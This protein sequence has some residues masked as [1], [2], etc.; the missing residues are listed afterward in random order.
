MKLT[1]FLP[2][3][4]DPLYYDT[5]K[6]L[7]DNSELGDQLEVIVVLDAWWP[8]KYHTDKRV[9]YV[10]H[11]TNTGM[12][13]AINTAVRVASGEYIARFD[14]H[15][16]V[17][18]GWDRILIE[19]YNNPDSEKWMVTGLRY[20]LDADKWEVMDIPPV[21]FQRLWIAGRERKKFA[22]V[23]WKT[24]DELLKDIDIAETL[25]H[26]GSF[27][28]MPKKLWNEVIGELSDE[29]YGP[30][31]QDSIEMTFKLWMAGG[32]LILNKKMWYAH[33]HRKFKRTHNYGGAEA[34]ACFDYAIRTWGNYYRRKIRQRIQYEAN[35][36]LHQ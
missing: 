7:L 23:S 24:R 10:H 5:V 29:G 1:A 25:G 35:I 15:I 13:G 4:K 14:E 30:H 3:Y 20:F 6:S 22:A 32:K 2:S 8:E 34:D 12:R 26:Q 16:I 19:T 28:C 31:Y 21:G 17:C 27:W 11:G 33:K 9:K 36:Y 18:P